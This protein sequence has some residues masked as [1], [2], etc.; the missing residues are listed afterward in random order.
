MRRSTLLILVACV[1]VAGARRSNVKP[2][3]GSM[4]SGSQDEASNTGSSSAPSHG[5]V[6]PRAPEAAGTMQPQLEHGQR[7]ESM[8]WPTVKEFRNLRPVEKLDGITQPWKVEW[9][10][11]R[12]QE[13]VSFVRKE[14]D[15]TEAMANRIYEI[16]GVPAQ[17]CKMYKLAKEKREGMYKWWMLC[18]W[19]R[20]AKTFSPSQLKSDYAVINELDQHY[21]LDAVLQNYDLAGWYGNVGKLVDGPVVRIDN[22]GS[23]T[24]RAS[25]LPKQRAID[26]SMNWEKRIKAFS[27]YP[28][29]IWNFR[30]YFAWYHAGYVPENTDP[31]GKALKELSGQV[32]KI[33]SKKEEV[34]EMIMREFAEGF[35]DEAEEISEILASR[36]SC[37]AELS[38]RTDSW[39]VQQMENLVGTDEILFPLPEPVIRGVKQICEDPDAVAPVLE[40][41]VVQ[42]TGCGWFRWPW[43]C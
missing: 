40:V 29:D 39:P 6:A 32:E 34:L 41:P 37:L 12:D 17:Q 31:R 25:K 24:V 14:A 2:I 21:L 9:D 3:V 26:S 22:G 16:Y 23:L 1:A 36:I 13:P 5:G 42:A 4:S 30:R 35:P 28:F 10:R 27:P 11:G 33:A 18:R 7:N 38:K 8:P 20:L 15:V 19:L 43:S